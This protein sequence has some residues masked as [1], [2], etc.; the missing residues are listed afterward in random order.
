M[1]FGIWATLILALV[2]TL[3]ACAIMLWRK[4]R[5]TLRTLGDSSEKMGESFADQSRAN[6]VLAGLTPVRDT[7]VFGGTERKIALR[8]QRAATKYVRRNRRQTRHE[9]AYARWQAFNR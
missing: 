7:D 8:E 6:L 1:W 4:A 3:I 5:K 9:E 2:L